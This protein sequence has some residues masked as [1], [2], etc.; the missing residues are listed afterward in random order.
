MQELALSKIWPASCRLV[1]NSQFQFG[2]VIKPEESSVAKAM[3]D[4]AKSFYVTKV[5]YIIND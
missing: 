3:I 1:D 2:H 4:K 5:I